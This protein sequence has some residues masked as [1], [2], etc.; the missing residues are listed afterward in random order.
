MRRAQA[1][2]R[3]DGIIHWRGR[4]FGNQF[5]G[6]CREEEQAAAGEHAMFEKAAP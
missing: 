6:A 2:D 1:L 3:L 4:L 5:A